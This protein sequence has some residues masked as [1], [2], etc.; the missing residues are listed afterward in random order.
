MPGGTTI[1]A[2]TLRLGN[3][4]ALGSTAGNTTVTAGS[5]DLTGNNT[6]TGATNITGG[7][8]LVTGSTGSGAVSVASGATLGGTGT[9]GG[10]T[11]VEGSIAPGNGGIGTLNV[12]NNLTWKGAATGT[13]DTDWIFE[14]GAGNTS[15]LLS[16]TGDFIAD[17]SLGSIFRFNFA[18]STDEGTF[19][20][21][22]WSGAS[23]GFDSS[24]FSYDNLGPLRAGTFSF[25][26]NSLEFTVTAVPE[27]STWISM[28][29]L[30]V[31]GA[32]IARR[33]RART[34]SRDGCGRGC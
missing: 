4:T 18:G 10:E 5:L 33:R 32:L 1:S 13:S 14:L 2:G 7:T 26:A 16:I 11:T 17:V 23:T 29:A 30:V 25:G 27:P 8:L 34:S 9:I 19:T 3:A 15:D 28:W 6:Y 24:S 31:S 20:L 12:A 22:S 21:V